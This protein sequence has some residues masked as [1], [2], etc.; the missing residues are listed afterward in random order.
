MKK[1]LR[2]SYGFALVCLLFS[3]QVHAQQKEW[4]APAT[5]D[6]VANPLKGDPSA[7]EAG[8]KIFTAMCAICHGVTGKGNGAG[9]VA[10]DPHPANFLSIV[11]KNES[12]GAIFWKMTEGRP[13]MASYKT[14]LTDQQR[15][16][17]VTYIRELEK[18]K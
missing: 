16:Q 2:K 10:L 14:L 11:V 1:R 6:E 5:A 8:K 17:L 13:P 3:M 9:S 18:K 12:D 15:W 7:I 4:V